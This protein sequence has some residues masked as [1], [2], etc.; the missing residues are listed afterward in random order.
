MSLRGYWNLIVDRADI[1]WGN[2]WTTRRPSPG[3]DEDGGKG[4]VITIFFMR[5]GRVW[6]AS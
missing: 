1:A 6:I 5:A 3:A 4:E 2:S